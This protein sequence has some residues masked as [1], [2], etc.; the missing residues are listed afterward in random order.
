MLLEVKDLHA[1]YGDSHILHGI[2]VRVGSGQRVAVLGRNGAGKTTLLKSIMNAGPTVRGVVRWNNADL[3]RTPTFQRARLGMGLVPEDRR[4]F[5]H[6][7]VKENIELA[8]FSAPDGKAMPATEVLDQFPMLKSLAERG[9]GQLSGGQQQILAVARA[10]AA[11]PKLLLLDEPTEGLAPIIVE[12]LAKDV[13]GTCEANG[14]SL[15]LCEQ[16]IWFSRA[17]TNYVYVI[18]SGSI[19]FSGDWAA[20]DA[21][22]QVAA[23]YL[24]V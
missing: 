2:E 5:T 7:S 10:I 3:G 18:D 23:R 4:I 13:R 12:Q 8:R 15:L 9:G 1:F 22:S 16:S 21:D 20:F 11:R 17:C 6:V 19:V 14:V 24:A